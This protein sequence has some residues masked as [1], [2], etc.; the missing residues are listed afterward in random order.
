M[1]LRLL[2]PFRTFVEDDE[3]RRL[4]NSRHRPI[5]A[6]LTEQRR[7]DPAIAEVVSK[8]FYGGKLTTEERRAKAAEAE[9]PPIIQLGALPKSLIVVVNFPHVSA[10][11]QGGEAR[12]R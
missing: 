11:G 2:E 10:T 1:G 3:R 5:A 9:E 7:M 6:T 4:A 12:A 8:A